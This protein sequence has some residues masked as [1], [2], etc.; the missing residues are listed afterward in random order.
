MIGAPVGSVRTPPLLEA[1]LARAGAPAPVEAREV[2]ADALPAF[3]AEARAD[4]SIAGLTVTMP[5]KRAIRPFLDE[6]TDVARAA[7]S[8]NAV[9]WRGGRLAGAQ[10]DGLALRSALHA[11]GVDLAASAVWLAGLGGAGLAI[12]LAL[13]AGGCARLFASE[14]NEAR[15]AA[16]LPLLGPGVRVVTPG[17]AAPADILVNATPLGMKAGDESPFPQEAVARAGLVADIVADPEATRLAGIT[18]AAGV[19]L[20]TGRTMVEHQIAPIGRW[21]L[22]DALAQEE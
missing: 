15:L 17:G 4:P 12:A 3:M 2:A 16:V 8:V 21:L 22:S 11:A 7:G 1:F 18:R 13:Q 14:G 19:R 20:V 6:E 10:F 9:K 5:H